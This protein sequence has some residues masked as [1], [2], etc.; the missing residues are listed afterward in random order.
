MYDGNDMIEHMFG[1]EQ[2]AVLALVDAAHS[3]LGW[4]WYRVAE[5]LSETG[6]A[7]D[8][9][10]GEWNGFEPD[11]ARRLHTLTD[12][13][14]QK[15]VHYQELIDDQAS[16]GSDLVTVLDPRYPRNLMEIY[17]RP[18]FLFIRG[19]LMPEDNRAIA[20]V[21]TRQASESGLKQAAELAAGLSDSGV[22]VLSGMASGIDTAAHRAALDAKGRT[23]AVM[24]TGIGKRYPAANRSLADEIEQRGA[25][26]SQFW[27]SAPPARW[28]FPMRNVVM[29]GMALGTVVIEAS[30]TSG[31]K[32]QARLALEHGKFVFLVKSLVLTQEWAR[33][34]ADRRGAIVVDHVDE[35]LE[36]L[37]AIADARSAAQLRLA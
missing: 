37:A 20:V 12:V 4:E 18:P 33:D 15:V 6:S 9:L 27:P 11:D 7:R 10:D 36:H 17:N 19:Q 24:G 22:T 23:V 13:V 34:Y 8:I 16:L 26:V 35:I 5:A 14:H 2:A 32:M 28:S 21:G 25:L 31:A 1:S 29:S 3:E 30:S